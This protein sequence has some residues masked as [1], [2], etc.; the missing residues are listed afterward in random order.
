MLY[1]PM[2]FFTIFRVRLTQGSPYLAPMLLFAC[3]IWMDIS[4]GTV[5]DQDQFNSWFYTQALV[6]WTS[7]YPMGETKAKNNVC[8]LF[9]MVV[10]WASPFSTGER[11]AVF[12]AVF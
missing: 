6:G 7:D 10:V 4:I 9:A 5:P 8:F 1:S 2:L 11:C 3:K 12:R